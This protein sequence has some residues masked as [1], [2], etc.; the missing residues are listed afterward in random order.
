MCESFFATL[1][2]EFLD[3][4]RFKTQAEARSAIFDFIEGFYKAAS[5]ASVQPRALAGLH[6]SLPNKRPKRS[7]HNLSK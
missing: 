4:C 3:R 2:C 5:M 1:E 7:Q 6:M